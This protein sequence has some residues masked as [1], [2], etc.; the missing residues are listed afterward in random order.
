MNLNIKFEGK[1]ILSP[2]F[3]LMKALD[4]KSAYVIEFYVI[5][6]NSIITPSNVR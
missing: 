2:E 1:D 4:P 5:V 3:G 6:L